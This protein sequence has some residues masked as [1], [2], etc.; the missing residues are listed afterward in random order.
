MLTNH[1][2]SVFCFFL[3]LFLFLFFV[4][5]FLFFF[6]FYQYD[7]VGLFILTAFQF[8]YTVLFIKRKFLQFHK[9]RESSSHSKN[10]NTRLGYF[11]FFYCTEDT[12]LT[13]EFLEHER[14][15]WRLFQKRIVYTKLDIYVFIIMWS[16]GRKFI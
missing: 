7:T 8:N 9:T 4:F 15:L 2:L 11:P 10:N 3:F 14:R 5:C 6:L 16:Y 1:I 13:F 12:I